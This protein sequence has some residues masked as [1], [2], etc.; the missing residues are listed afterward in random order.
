MQ[1]ISN[2]FATYISYRQKYCYP[3][4][5]KINYNSHFWSFWSVLCREELRHS[6]LLYS[7]HPVAVEPRR[8]ARNDNRVSLRCGSLFRGE[9]V[10]CIQDTLFLRSSALFYHNCGKE[11]VMSINSACNFWWCHTIWRCSASLL[12]FLLGGWSNRRRG[13]ASSSSSSSTLFTAGGSLRRRCG[14]HRLRC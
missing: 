6:S 12:L 14:F 4:V 5:K 10:P 1:L 9:L 13:V 11:T 8:V 3:I 2:Y 7:V